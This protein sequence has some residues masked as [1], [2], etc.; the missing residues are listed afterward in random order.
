MTYIGDNYGGKGSRFIPLVIATAL[1]A[2]M[3]KKPVRCQLTR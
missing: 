3:T 2:K 1:A